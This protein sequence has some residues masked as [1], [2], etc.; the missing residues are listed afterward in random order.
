MRSLPC[1]SQKRALHDSPDAVSRR[2][3]PP[4]L[5]RMQSR[6]TYAANAPIVGN[7]AH[8]T[9]KY[10]ERSVQ[11]GQTIRGL[12]HRH[13]GFMGENDSF[14]PEVLLTLK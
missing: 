1:T 12:V 11:P 10:S 9:F 8:A 5:T 14:F 13:C 3:T 4:L 2:Y 6:G 7:V